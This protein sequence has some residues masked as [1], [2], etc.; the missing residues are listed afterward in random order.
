MG[1]GA[2]TIGR[3]LYGLPTPA[4]FTHTHVFPTLLFYYNDLFSSLV[5]LTPLGPTRTRQT[6][7]SLLPR[8]LRSPLLRPLQWAMGV[9]F[10]VLGGRVLR[11][12][13]NLWP[14]IQRGLAA[15]SHRGA[16]SRREERVYAFQESIA[17]R[18]PA[19]R[20]RPDDAPARDPETAGRALF[21]PA[22]AVHTRSQG[23]ECSP[24]EGRSA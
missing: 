13:M 19:A 18:V 16:L 15:S 6:A 23:T 10:G 1:F 5:A 20:A 7:V 17:A 3:L 2:R 4:R 12:D 14:A 11:E 22:G 8:R 21:A 9:A 24:T